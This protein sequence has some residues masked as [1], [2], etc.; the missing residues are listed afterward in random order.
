MCIVSM[1]WRCAQ[2]FHASGLSRPQRSNKIGHDL[3][4]LATKEIWYHI[5]L[6]RR[7]GI[8]VCLLLNCLTQFA[9]QGTRIVWS[10]YDSQD[11]HPGTYGICSVRDLFH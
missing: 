9:N 8:D 3:Y 5:P 6:R 2:F 10:D 4:G 1:P 7:L 11:T